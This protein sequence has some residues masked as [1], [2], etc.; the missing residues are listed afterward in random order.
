MNTMKHALFYLIPFLA[1]FHLSCIEYSLTRVD[2]LHTQYASPQGLKTANNIDK[3]LHASLTSS[4]STQDTITTTTKHTTVGGDDDKRVE[5]TQANNYS[6][7]NEN[8]SA[9]LSLIYVDKSYALGTNLQ[10][11]QVGKELFQIPP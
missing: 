7:L 6:T 9:E 8:K 5:P 1:L 2:Y 4:I 3:G 10:F 11:S